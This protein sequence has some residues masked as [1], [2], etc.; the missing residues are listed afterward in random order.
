MRKRSLA[1]IALLYHYKAK[2]LKLSPMKYFCRLLY[3]RASELNL[4]FRSGRLFQQYSCEMFVKVECERLP[5]LRQNE[6]TLRS[7]DYTHLCELPADSSMAK[8][9]IKEWKKSREGKNNCRRE[10]GRT[11]IYAYRSERDMRKMI[12]D[13]IAISNSIGHPDVFIAMSCYPYWLEIQN[14]LLS[15]QKADD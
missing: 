5:F 11:S 14:D 7:S 12:H 9:E 3:Q 10:V 8:N 13:I 1:L 2:L 4:I 6:S 15:G